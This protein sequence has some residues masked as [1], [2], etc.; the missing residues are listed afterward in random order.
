MREQRQSV[1]VVG[2]GI[3]GLVS[4]F[5]LLQDGHAVTVFDPA[6]AKGATWAAAGMIAPTAEIAV[7]EEA[8][9]ALQ[10]NALPAWRAL[11]EELLALT[12]EPL[13][14][15][16]NG[17][18]LV[19]WDASDRRLVDQ[20]AQVA[21]EFGAD[22]RE[23][24]RDERP[25]EFEGVSARITRGLLLPGDAWVNPDD[26]VRLLLS[27]LELLGA[28]IIASE[29]TRI[30]SGDHDVRVFTDVG[31][32]AGGCGLLA[33]GAAGLVAGAPTGARNAVRP[34]RG[35]TLRVRGLDRSGVAT[36]RALVRGRP[37]YALSRPGGY[38]VLGA[39]VDERAEL[40][41]ELGELQRLTRDALD[42]LPSLE[43]AEV[44]EHRSGLRPASRD[45]APFFERLDDS[46]WAWSSGHYRHGVTLA[47]LAGVEAVDFVRGLA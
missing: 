27:S 26:A 38:G 34:V 45:L 28:K 25:E 33:T 47:P 10:R 46:R 30:E 12:G 21:R 44:L 36:L 1:L 35:V 8:N 31:D 42:V 17:T 14:I 37:F 24:S 7:G 19:G 4:A 41:L 11:G 22:V 3:I 32:Y 43:S 16:E 5:R 9:H 20:F 39:S 2:A 29:V 18:L 40:A 15:V 23:C 13:Q 6:P